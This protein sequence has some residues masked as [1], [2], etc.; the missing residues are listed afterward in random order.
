M[1]HR[2]KSTAG[3]RNFNHLLVTKAF[4]WLLPENW[5]T[6]ESGDLTSGRGVECGANLRG[7]KERAKRARTM[8]DVEHVNAVNHSMEWTQWRLGGGFKI[9]GTGAPHSALW[10]HDTSRNAAGRILRS[11]RLEIANRESKQTEGKDR[12]VE[13]ISSLWAGE[14]SSA[15]TALLQRGSSRRESS[16]LF[17]EL[18]L[19]NWREETYA[20]DKSLNKLKS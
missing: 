7:E 9:G 19:K 8:D 14:A 1:L 2:S 12:R 15:A 16:A 5:R 3:H 4:Q 20:R 18:C 11:R 10:R 17:V 6:E 13:E